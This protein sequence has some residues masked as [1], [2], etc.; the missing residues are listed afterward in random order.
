V[1]KLIIY[2]TG[3]I[4][5]VAH[6]YFSLD[7]E[8]EVVA[9]ANAEAYIQN[10][11]FLDLPVV[12]FETCDERFAPESHDMFVAVG[13]KKTNQIRQARYEEARE[14]GYH[15][16]SYISPRA[17][18]YGTPVGDNCFIL[19]HNVIQPGVRIGNNVT[20][21]CGNHIGH[22]SVI[23]DHCF[24]SSHVVVSGGCCIGRNCFLG[25]NAAL[26][27]NITIEAYTVVGV[28]A[29]VMKD[30]GERSLVR[31]ARSDYRVVDRD[32]I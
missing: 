16:A 25:V 23:D 6:F 1:T 29:A 12:A 28:G 32:V 13:Y 7:T 27:D 31:A 24:V 10:H 19:E 4:A 20:L 3:A 11:S 14:M 22:H 21:W 15:C 8:Y 30:C 2:G 17:T 18:Y 9:F 26:R 5:E